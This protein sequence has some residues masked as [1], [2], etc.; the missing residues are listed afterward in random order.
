MLFLSS[1]ALQPIHFHMCNSVAGSLVEKNTIRNSNQRCIVVHGSDDVQVVENIAFDNAGHCIILE[2]GAEQNNQFVRNLVAGTHPVDVL[3]SD[4]ESDNVPSSFW[5]TNPVNTWIGNVAAGSVGAGYWFEVS[6][7]V[8]GPSQSLHPDMQPNRL[9]LHL[10]IDNVSHSNSRNGLQTYPQSGY[11]PSERAVFQ[12]HK[13]FRNRAAGV[14]FHAGFNLTLDG[15]YFADNRVGVDI[16]VDHSD[17]VKNSV[18]VG[19]SDAYQAVVDSLGPAAYSYPA[20]AQCLEGNPVVG[21]RLDSS[22]TELVNVTFS[23]LGP[24]ACPGSA[25][26]DCH[27]HKS[28]FQYMDTLSCITIMDDSVPVNFCKAVDYGIT[29]I[30]VRDLDGSFLEG[31]PGSVV[32]DTHAMKA[33]P[34][35]TPVP[36][37]CAAFCPRRPDPQLDGRRFGP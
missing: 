8:R 36:G 32:A 20:R 13:S 16:D 30:A 29:D 10:F 34:R 9:P 5:I 28:T 27:A 25:V 33:D 3:I 24:S 4:A 17:Q 1:T 18:I 37:S 21:V 6:G 19:V 12:N 11:K 14:F 15:G 26:L 31:T 23:K 35:C 7:S 2:D 22:G